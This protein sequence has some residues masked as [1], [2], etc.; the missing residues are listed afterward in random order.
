M[1]LVYGM[2]LLFLMWLVSALMEAIYKVKPDSLVLA[3]FAGAVFAG[4]YFYFDAKKK[5]DEALIA[6]KKVE[7]VVKAEQIEAAKQL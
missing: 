7:A 4:M 5:T 3:G 1:L 2:S 6:A